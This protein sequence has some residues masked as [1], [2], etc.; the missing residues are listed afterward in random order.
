M[1]I[2]DTTF[3][4]LRT[5]YAYGT[6]NA[7]V[8]ARPRAGVGGSVPSV[9]I[10]FF[11]THDLRYRLRLRPSMP[12]PR[13]SIRTPT[14]LRLVYHFKRHVNPSKGAATIGTVSQ[15]L[16]AES[17]APA[18][19]VCSMACSMASHACL[20][21][22]QPLPLLRRVALLPSPTPIAQTGTVS[23]ID[24][25]SPHLIGGLLELCIQAGE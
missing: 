5:R 11:S 8:N 6:D 16:T 21:R 12:C 17:A 7:T 25:L 2:R 3:E 9:N 19:S 13:T 15:R 14:A 22:A 24:S 18:A 1:R 4:V 23:T 20:A 10:T